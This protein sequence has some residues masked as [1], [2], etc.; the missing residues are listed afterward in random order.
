[1]RQK[2]YLIRH[3]MTCGNASGK[4]IGCRTDDVLSVEG[5]KE[6]IRRSGLISARISSGAKFF[7]GPMTRCVSTANL[8]FPQKNVHIID[9]LYEMDFGVF[10]GKT[11]NEL[12]NDSVFRKWIDS[13]GMTAPPE[14]ESI[15][16]MTGR[17]VVGLYK[18]LDLTK[19][20]EEVV[21]V[22]HG[23]NIMTIMSA[24]FG[25]DPYDYH[26]DN[27]EGYV[28]EGK[29]NTFEKIR[30][31]KRISDLTYSRFITGDIA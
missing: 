14:G 15:T 16:D 2:I 6:A 21:I 10:E 13:R 27:L 7:S 3:A 20:T 4:Y 11:Y 1:M 24:L 29:I 8:L 31:D 22:C 9:E 12:E 30:N 23:G 25:D 19:D 5:R 28:I 18:A 26:V 17:S